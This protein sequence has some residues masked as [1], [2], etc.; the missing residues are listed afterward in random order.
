MLPRVGPRA[1]GQGVTNVVMGDGLTIISGQQV[2]PVAVAV[3]IPYSTR[4]CALGAGEYQ[5][6][7][8]SACL[9]LYTHPKTD[10]RSDV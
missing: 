4:Y 6:S 1:V 8:T 10:F 5:P 2:T 3:G 9:D 7:V